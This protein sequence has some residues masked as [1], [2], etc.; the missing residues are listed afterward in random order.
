MKFEIET[1]S[2]GGQIVK[3]SLEQH[4][5]GVV[6]KAK[7]DS[8]EWSVMSFRGGKFRRI[9]SIPK[10]AGIDV[11]DIGRMLERRSGD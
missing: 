2:C 4:S 9:S 8:E 5:N 11:D 1:E 7:I 6:L 10:D 3:L